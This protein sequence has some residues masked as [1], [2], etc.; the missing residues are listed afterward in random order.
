M[1]KNIL[2][3]FAILIS[4]NF[5]K[6]QDSLVSKKYSFG[7]YSKEFGIGAA[8]I[9]KDRA[10]LFNITSNCVTGTCQHGLGMAL[11]SYNGQLLKSAAFGH[12]INDFDVVEA[13]GSSDG[14]CMT[15]GNS[16]GDIVILQ[17][18]DTNLNIVW[19][20]ALPLDASVDQSGLYLN[21][22]QEIDNKH[23]VLYANQWLTFSNA[24]T[25][26]ASKRYFNG[27]NAKSRFDLSAIKKLNSNRFVLGGHICDAAGFDSE[28]IN[29][30]S[31]SK[32]AASQI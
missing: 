26:L 5:C 13:Y 2:L 16:T 15:L 18:I 19:N 25:L 8:Q 7:G 4:S 12:A 30:G 20:K 10:M 17:K 32:P 1:K 9:N 23:H 11:I 29:I 3:I 14:S 24:G 22:L 28:T 27:F 31:E 21:A 6:A